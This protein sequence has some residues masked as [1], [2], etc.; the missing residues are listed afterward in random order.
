MSIPISQCIPPPAVSYLKCKVMTCIRMT[1]M[2]VCVRSD[3][4]NHGHRWDYWVRDCKVNREKGP[5]LGSEELLQRPWRREQS[6][7]RVGRKTRRGFL[8]SRCLGKE[9]VISSNNVSMKSNRVWTKPHPLDILETWRR[10][11]PNWSRLRGDWEGSKWRLGD[12]RMHVGASQTL[13]LCGTYRKFF[14]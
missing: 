2:G 11:K 13:S 9:G 7:L 5:G 10:Q 4:L 8:L 14:F 6:L 3:H 12:G 1:D